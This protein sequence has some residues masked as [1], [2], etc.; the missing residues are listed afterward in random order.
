MFAPK[1][2]RQKI[3]HYTRRMNALKARFTFDPTEPTSLL[4]QPEAD[5]TLRLVG[6]MYTAPASIALEDLNRRIPLSIAQWHQH[7]S[8][9]MPPGASDDDSGGMGLATRDPRFGPRGS[10]TTEDE[11]TAAGGE[12]KQRMFNWMV[13]VNMFESGAAVWEHRH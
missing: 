11:C 9:C 6:A 12:F 5:G 8:I 7:V 1:L 2:K 3:F 10:I 13:H 4:Y